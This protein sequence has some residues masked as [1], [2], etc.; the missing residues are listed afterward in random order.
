MKERD[1]FSKA[2]NSIVLNRS[3][4]SFNPSQ[5]TFVFP[6]LDKD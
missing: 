3:E 1:V 6:G 5:E 2:N 4:S